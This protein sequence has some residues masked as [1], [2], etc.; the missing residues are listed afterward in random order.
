MFWRTVNKSKDVGLTSG[1][2]GM[3]EDNV[4]CLT[5]VISPANM[6]YMQEKTMGHSGVF[7]GG[8]ATRSRSEQQK[9][10][11]DE[12]CESGGRNFDGYWRYSQWQAAAPG[13]AGRPG[14]Q[15]GRGPSMPMPQYIGWQSARRHLG[16]A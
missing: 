5:G 13:W 3:H 7:W 4:A 9:G 16:H 2:R 8:T 1:R 10:S 11:E 12:S 6:S 14:D 15:V